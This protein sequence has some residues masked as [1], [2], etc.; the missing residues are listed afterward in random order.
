MNEVNVIVIDGKTINYGD[1]SG[2]KM[3]SLYKQLKEREI[4]LLKKIIKLRETY[5][6]LPEINLNE[7]IG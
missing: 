3:L 6:F 4:V 7:I 2:D 1:M 5:D